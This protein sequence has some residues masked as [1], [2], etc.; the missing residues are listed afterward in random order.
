VVGN[1]VVLKMNV[2]GQ[3]LL[4]AKVDCEMLFEIDAAV[5]GVGADAVYGVYGVY[6]GD[7]LMVLVV[8]K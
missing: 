6:Y 2:E 1:G 7:G 3:V 8:V 4:V 5:D